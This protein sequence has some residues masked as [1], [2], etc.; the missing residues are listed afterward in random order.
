VLADIIGHE[1]TKQRLMAAGGEVLRESKGSV[2]AVRNGILLHGE[3]GNGKTIFAE[4]IA[5]ELKVPLVTLAYA[6]VAS[7]WVGEKSSRVRDAF[8]EA[9]RNQPCV[10]F[11]DEIDSFLESR[12]AAGEVKEDRDLVNALLTL[13]VDLR[14]SRVLLIAATNYLDRLDAAGVREGRF[15]FKVEIAPPDRQARIAILGQALRK[16]LPR[17]RVSPQLIESVA[18]RW[19]GYSVKRILAVAGNCRLTCGGR[20]ARAPTTA[21]LWAR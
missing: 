13:T 19:N 11:I 16:H 5:G 18:S 10:I 4:A 8:D 7:K 14:G 20:G 3:P 9:R 12:G 21:I 2:G 15:D 6:D 17:Q 1:E